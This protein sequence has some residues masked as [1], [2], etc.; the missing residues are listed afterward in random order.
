MQPV[1]PCR[2]FI[3]LDE[4]ARQPWHQLEYGGEAGVVRDEEFAPDRARVALALI[5]V[6]D[7][8]IDALGLALHDQ[9]RGVVVRLLLGRLPNDDIGARA[10]VTVLRPPLLVHLRQRIAIVVDQ[11]PDEGLSDDLLRLRGHVSP[12]CPQGNPEP[13]AFAMKRVGS[14]RERR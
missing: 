2:A 10:F 6:L 8:D 1:S 5:V 9:D 3:E 14:G 4:I 12:L 7:V 11:M 13:L